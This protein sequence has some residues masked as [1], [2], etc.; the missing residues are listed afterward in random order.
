LTALCGS[1]L[2]V[3][4]RATLR[5][6]THP[7]TGE[8]LDRG[9]VVWFPEGASFTGEPSGELQVHGSRAVVG[10]IL[11]ALAEVPGCRAALPGEFTRRAF[12]NGRLDLAQVEAL[13]DLIAADTVRA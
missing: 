6:I 12:E 11:G 7:G 8:E 3:A 1:P 2:P 5:R 10:A 9:L 4:R 13:D